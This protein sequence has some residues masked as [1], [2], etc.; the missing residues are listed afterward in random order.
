MAKNDSSDACS[1]AGC[2]NSATVMIVPRGKWKNVKPKLA[3]QK[4]APGIEAAYKTEPGAAVA[5]WADVHRLTRGASSSAG[6]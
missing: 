3:C 5:G 4:C 2:F 6:K 1:G